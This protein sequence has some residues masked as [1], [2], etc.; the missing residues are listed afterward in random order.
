MRKTAYKGMWEVIYYEK[1]SGE[2]PVCAFIDSNAVKMRAKIMKEIG[3]LEEFG[4][5]LKMPYSKPI[6]DGLFELRIELGSDYTRIFY[7]FYTGKRIILTNGYLKKKNKAP[8]S[9][10]ERAFKYKADFER[11]F[12]E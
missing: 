11:R 8:E 1:T 12:A 6:R 4:T 10:L 9:E 5:E 2:C 3:L 7:F